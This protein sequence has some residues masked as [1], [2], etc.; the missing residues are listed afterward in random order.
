MFFSTLKDIIQAQNK[1]NHLIICL[2][3]IS[4]EC[5][6]FSVNAITSLKFLGALGGLS[7]GTQVLRNSEGTWTLGGHAKDTDALIFP[8]FCA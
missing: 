8:Y 5:F 4:E 3:S 7:E 1:T 2:K 6:S